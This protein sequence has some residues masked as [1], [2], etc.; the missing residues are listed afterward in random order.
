MPHH[1]IGDGGEKSRDFSG[2]GCE[3]SCRR[4]G[5]AEKQIAVFRDEVGGD[6]LFVVL[7]SLRVLQIELDRFAVFFSPSVESFGKPVSRGV[8]SRMR[9]N[10]QHPDSVIGFGGVSATGHASHSHSQRRGERN[11]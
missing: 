6:G 11:A 1:G 10:L 4:S 5:Y 3:R 7:I 8:Q 2:R 9:C